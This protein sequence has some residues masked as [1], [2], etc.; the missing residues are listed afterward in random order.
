[1]GRYYCHDDYEH[2]RDAERDARRGIPDR[3]YYDRY[4]YDACKEVYTKTYDD[5]RRR[6]AFHESQ[7]QERDDEERRVRQ[8]SEWERE[9]AEEYESQ[10]IQEEEQVEPEPDTCHECG[11][12]AVGFDHDTSAMLCAKCYRKKPTA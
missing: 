2:R 6:L 8:R 5:E 4:S 7:R 12:L 10:L 11:E 1:M 3:D 9:R